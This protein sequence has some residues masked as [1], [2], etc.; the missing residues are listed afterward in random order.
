[1][2]PLMYIIN[3]NK[4]HVRVKNEMTWIFAKNCVDL[5]SISEVR[6][7]GPIFWPTLYMYT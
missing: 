6:S 4:L 3:F 1:M 2:A 7:C 5:S